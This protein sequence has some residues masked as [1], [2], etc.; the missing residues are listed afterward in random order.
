MISK[1][2]GCAESALAAST[3]LLPSASTV[4][5]NVLGRRKRGMLF[6]LIV[7]V[8]GLLFP[9]APYSSNIATARTKPADA[10]L[11]L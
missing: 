1:I 5:S 9:Q 11:I 3:R 8:R 6:S 2:L 4:A 7:L 10:C